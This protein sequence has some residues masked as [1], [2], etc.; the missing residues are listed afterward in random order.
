MQVPNKY[1]IATPMN[2]LSEIL[3]FEFCIAGFGLPGFK[4]SYEKSA[5]TYFAKRTI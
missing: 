5:V 1:Q 3:K 2:T 4:V